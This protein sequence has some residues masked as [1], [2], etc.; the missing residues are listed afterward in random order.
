MRAGWIAAV[1]LA[2]A[3]AVLFQPVVD[4]GFLNW[5]D[6]DVVAANPQ[7]Q[8][9]PGELAAWAAT[10]RDMGHYQPV[11]WLTLAG[12]AGRPP[13]PA[14]VHGAAV[15]LHALNAVLLFAVIALVLG[16]GAGR[17]RWAP[18]AAAAALFA[19]H[20]LR[21]EPVAW[22]S[23]LPYLLAYAPLLAATGAWI[24][25]S[26]G[27]H[28][29]WLAA[30]LVLFVVSQ[31][32]RVTAPLYAVVLV[33]AWWASGGTG[34]RTAAVLGRA[35]TPFAVLGL[36]FAGLE[37][38]ARGAESLTDYPFGVRLSWA[39]ANP[40][41]YLWRSVA[42]VGL[43]P[44]DP[45]PREAAVDWTRTALALGG[46]L[47]VVAATWWR[48]GRGAAVAVWGAYLA[49]LLP[50]VGLVA[51]GLQLTADR[52]TYGPAMVLAV[53]V[54]AALSG[55]RPPAQR[56]ALAA[57]VV[58]AVAL[59]AATR[60][61]LPHWRDSASLWHRAL[62]VDADNDVARYN[63]A[64]AELSA[65]RND[66]AEAHLARVLADVPDHA[67]ARAQ[68]ATLRADRAQRAA[69][70]AAAAGRLDEAIR[71]YDETLAHDPGRTRARLTRG[72]A[73]VRSGAAARAV[74]DLEA[75][76]AADS[77]DP[78]VAGALALAWTE[79][80]R[81]A[82]AIALLRRMRERQPRNL[83]VTMNLARLLLTATP[84]ALRDPE[85]A[86]GLV[87]GVNDATGG[88]NPRVLATLAEALAATGRHRDAAEAWAV[89][90]TLADESG[91]AALTADLRRRAASGR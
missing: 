19:W 60:V 53:A 17:G 9:P 40:A 29:G 52:Y 28:G 46:G 74:A 39:L 61:A 37:A 22:A 4:H 41:A 16:E 72:M 59:A 34:R 18:A 33:A 20:P 85:A 66:E 47:S 3:T 5:D 58:A 43:T 68:L 51:S 25:W 82:D 13:S 78:A 70:A 54:A 86:L 11:A 2:L 65:G 71:G 55:L 45:L 83:S 87:A 8:Q 24:R 75:A 15:A 77:A 63:L 23:A 57:A 1:V 91:D 73:L 84:M 88:Q 67:P 89:A 69:D 31:L 48:W 21:V 44:L 32:V 26:R 81:S 6:P 64:L 27:G 38:W 62:A 80:G 36:A 49:L 42:P 10:T 14:R 12:I 35:V 90:I 56:V 79:T 7:L 76:G 30:S 50:V